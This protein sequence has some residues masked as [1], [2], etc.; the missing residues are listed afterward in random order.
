MTVPPQHSIEELPHKEEEDK[1]AVTSEFWLEWIII[2]LLDSSS[3]HVP[4]A[5][6]ASSDTSRIITG[7]S[8]SEDFALDSGRSAMNIK[9]YLVDFFSIYNIHTRN[10]LR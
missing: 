5:S 9:G 7:R 3:S 8:M 10:L 4:H 2:S 6:A 1:S